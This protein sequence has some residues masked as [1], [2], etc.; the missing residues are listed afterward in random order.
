[1]AE[2]DVVRQGPV[3]RRTFLGTAAAGG[4]A[5]AA[6]ACGGPGEAAEGAAVRTQQNVQWRLASSFPRTLEALY[7]SAERLAQ[8]VSEL[9]EGRFR[10]RTYPAGELVPALQVMDAAQQGTVQVGHSAGY[11]YTGKN[12][13][14]AFDTGVPFGLTSRQQSAWLYEAGGLDLLDEAGIFRKEAVA[15]VDGLGARP[16]RGVDDAPG[17]EIA[18]ADGRSAD[19]HRLVGHGDMQRAGVGVGMDGD[20]GDA[21]A[22]RGADDAAG[23]L[24]AVGDQDLVEH[25]FSSGGGLDTVRERPR[26]PA[27]VAWRA[28]RTV[29]VAAALLLPWRPATIRERR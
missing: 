28:A 20:G 27:L 6:A 18:F 3:D 9:T 4:L 26:H 22:P 10:I 16:Y 21:H 8:K 17:H 15:G 29:A 23:D 5:A 2:S 1:M 19:M 11:Y 25:R 24:A 13:A 12:E 14:L 7:G